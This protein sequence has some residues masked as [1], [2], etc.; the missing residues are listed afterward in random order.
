V[1]LQVY[2]S[3]KEAPEAF[4]TSHLPVLLQIILAIRS[5][6]RQTSPFSDFPSQNSRYKNGTTK[7]RSLAF[8]VVP[9]RA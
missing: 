6:D 4:R 2:G 7:T 9:Y 8:L 1:S 5:Q 3:R